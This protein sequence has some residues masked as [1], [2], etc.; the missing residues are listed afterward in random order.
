MSF[1]KLLFLRA[2]KAVGLITIIISE[3]QEYTILCPLVAYLVLLKCYAKSSLLLF[4][5]AVAQGL[6]PWRIADGTVPSPRRCAFHCTLDRQRARVAY[7][8]MAQTACPCCQK[9]SEPFLPQRRSGFEICLEPFK[10]WSHQSEM[11]SHYALLVR[12]SQLMYFIS[13]QSGNPSCFFL[14]GFNPFPSLMVFSQHLIYLPISV[15][16]GFILILGFKLIIPWRIQLLPLTMCFLCIFSK[17]FS[18][19]I[20]WE[21]NLS[22]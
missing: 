6:W 19:M 9:Q 18:E 17:D 3:L 5:K 20:T 14:L 7:A 10:M 4:C 8:A 13:F 12:F 15:F 11:Q 2:L 22:Y 16:I 1:Y 21:T